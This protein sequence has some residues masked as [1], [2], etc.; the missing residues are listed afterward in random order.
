MDVKRAAPDPE[1]R[2]ESP[3]PHAAWIVGVVLLALAAGVMLGAGLARH[4]G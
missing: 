1:V 3:L 2:Y 4:W